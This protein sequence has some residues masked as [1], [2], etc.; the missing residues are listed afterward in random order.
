MDEQKKPAPG[1][2]HETPQAASAR[3]DFIFGNEEKQRKINLK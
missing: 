2:D 1:K 3:E